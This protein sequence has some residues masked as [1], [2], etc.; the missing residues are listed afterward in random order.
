MKLAFKRYT[1]ACVHENGMTINVHKMLLY[2]LAC[3][4]SCAKLFNSL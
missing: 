3:V 4:Y 1:L 2:I